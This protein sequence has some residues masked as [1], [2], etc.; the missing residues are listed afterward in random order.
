MDIGSEV[1]V[2]DVEEPSFEPYEIEIGPIEVEEP[3][4]NA[5]EGNPKRV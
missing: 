2:I 5:G 3:A 1:R 4:R